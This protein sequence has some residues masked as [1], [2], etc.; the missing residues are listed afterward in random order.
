[1]GKHNHSQRN[2][3]EDLSRAVVCP[4]EFLEHGSGPPFKP[5]FCR[6]DPSFIHLG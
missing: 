1:M 3:C 5:L 4:Q 6:A 2:A